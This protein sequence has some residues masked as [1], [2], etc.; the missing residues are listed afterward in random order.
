MIRNMTFPEV[1]E[2]LENEAECV[3]R[4]STCSRDCGNCEL[5]RKD[6]DIIE[7]YRIAIGI[8]KEKIKEQELIEE[9]KK[10]DNS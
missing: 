7:A 8:V 2:Y 5:V 6:E 3:R 1:V 10:N 9:L 4:G